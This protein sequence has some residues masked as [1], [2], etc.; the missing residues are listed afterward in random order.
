MQEAVSYRSPTRQVCARKSCGMQ[1]ATK[2][3]FPIN[4]ADHIHMKPFLESQS[5]FEENDLKI[6]LICP[7]NGIAVLKGITHTS[8]SLNIMIGCIP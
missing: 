5:R 1:I 6:E 8:L 2:Q 4:R 3:R 7:Q